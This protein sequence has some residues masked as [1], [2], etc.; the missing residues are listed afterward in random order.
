MGLCDLD[1][2]E[3]YAVSDS[4]FAASAGCGGPTGGGVCPM[5]GD[6]GNISMRD[7]LD[8]S[9]TQGVRPYF[10]SWALEW[11]LAGLLAGSVAGVAHANP[12]G[13]T[14]VHG[15]VEFSNPSAGT[16]NVTASSNAIINWQ[17]FSIGADELTRF[18]QPGTGSAVLNRVVGSGSS[19][20]LGQLLSN[21]RVFLV[22]PHGIVFGENASVDTAGLVASTL[23]I[24][25]ADFLEGD[26]R[27][28]AGPD[29]GKITN[30]GSIEAGAGGVFLLAPSVE[31]SGVIHTEGGDLVLAAG[32]T[33]TLTSLDLGG[34]QVEVQAPEDEALNLGTLL[35]ERGAAGVFAGSIRNAGTVEANAVT[36][37]EDGTVH[38]VFEDGLD[39]EGGGA[40][41][42]RGAR[43]LRS[44]CRHGAPG[45]SGGHHPGGRGARSG[46]R[47]L[48]R[49]R[50]HRERVR[51]HVGLG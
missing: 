10:G 25:D 50:A 2:A 4:D 39:L 43:E 18:I 31:N 16:L 38:L 27:F 26:Y 3:E 6:S 12:T 33:I 22:N 14:V 35:A 19:E 21:G 45:G 15:S 46:R 7:S 37:D 30:E 44:Q 8:H 1:N 5:H 41:R 49:R 13:S 47:A 24:S 29:A 20:I 48:G 17:G 51:N 36:V 42:G 23:G 28:D 32:R 40:R 11:L 9:P 34:V